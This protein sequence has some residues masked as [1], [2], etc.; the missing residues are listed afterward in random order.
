MLYFTSYNADLAVGAATLDKRKRRLHSLLREG[1]GR[2][3]VEDN[4]EPPDE[5]EHLG[6]GWPA[7]QLSRE[8]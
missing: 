1:E 3:C 2:G 8:R 6:L 5:A 7:E 4:L